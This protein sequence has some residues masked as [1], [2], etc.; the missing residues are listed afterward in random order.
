LLFLGAAL[1]GGVSLIHRGLLAQERIKSAEAPKLAA[2]GSSIEQVRTID[3]EL[4]AGWKDRHLSPSHAA[5]DYEF[6]RRVS[7][8]I[9]GRVATPDEITR[10]LHD[11][12]HL[13]RTYLVDRLLN[14]PEYAR[15]WAA[16]WTVWLMT[17]TGPEP[18]HDEMRSWLEEQFAKPKHAFD[19]TAT[20]LLTATGKNTENGAVNFVL[21]H[22]GEPVPADKRAEEGQ[23][24]MVPI[25]SRTTRLFLGLQIQ[26]TQCHD[27]PTNP[28]QWKQQNF[29]GINAFFRQVERKGTAMPTRDAPAPVLEL[30]DNPKWNEDSV[31]FFERRNGVVLPSRARFLDG[32]KATPHSEGMTR[33]QELAHFVVTNDYFARAFV[34]RM[35]AHFFGRGMNY[36]GAADDFGEHNPLS[37]PK[38]L[39]YL[40]QQF[41]E[42][43]HN[44]RDVI[45]W[46]CNSEAYGLSSAANKTNDKPEAEPYCSRMLLKAMSPEQLFESLMTVTRADAGQ[47]PEEKKKLREEWLRKLVVNF[48]DD[49]GTEVTFNGTVVQALILMNGREINEALSH[50]D[51]GP[52]TAAL[53]RPR[54]NVNTI[55]DDLY[56]AALNRRPTESEYHAIARGL[57]VRVRDSDVTGPWQDLLWALLNSNEFILNH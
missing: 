36:P 19:A 12:A 25:T 11:P 46:I 22:L 4:Q 2:V 24:N 13:R 10:F 44:P 55:V 9:I 42:H 32:R 27:H 43:G 6:I 34:N 16:I 51:R 31:V 5:T 1:A 37:N 33:R 21:A 15:N 39:D 23:F 40:A 54:A 20:E 56:L 26:C 38:L 49:E 17:R 14:S 3:R 7:L 45:R 47:R 28:D 35:W 30:T 48:G 8:D 57:P 50:K 18:Y 52:I 53:R 29:W 41:R